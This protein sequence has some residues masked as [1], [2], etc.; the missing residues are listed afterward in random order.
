MLELIKGVKE[1][2]LR[3]ADEATPGGLLGHDG[4]KNSPSSTVGLAAI[5]E[6]PTEHGAGER[7]WSAEAADGNTT[8][9][10]EASSTSKRVAALEQQI[11]R[12]AAQIAQRADALG[13]KFS[14]SAL[15]Q[16]LE[17]LRVKL[18]QL[19]DQL[20]IAKG[21]E[22]AAVRA[23]GATGS[24]IKHDHLIDQ[25][26][27]RPNLVADDDAGYRAPESPPAGGVSF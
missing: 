1:K 14:A 13:G 17:P 23:G 15:D 8:V 12:A 5:I 6:D 4:S 20:E 27:K 24:V 19:K 9:H 21:A 3:G 22:A 18:D 11:A 2:Q 25:L 10:V 16:Y 26:N 7:R